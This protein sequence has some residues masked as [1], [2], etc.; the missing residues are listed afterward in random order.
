MT[1]VLAKVKIIILCSFICPRRILDFLSR[2]KNF[3][4]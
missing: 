4:T 3:K 1:A 2:E